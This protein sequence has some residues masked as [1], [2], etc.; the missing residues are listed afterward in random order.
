MTTVRAGDSI[1]TCC[2]VCGEQ[3]AILVDV[4]LA[5]NQSELSPYPFCEYC[6][7]MNAKEAKALTEEGLEGALIDPY[8][9][10]I[11][12]K[13]KKAAAKGDYSIYHPFHGMQNYP[14]LNI[15]EA[16]FNKLRKDGYKITSH[17]GDRPMDTPYDQISWE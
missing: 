5:G 16:V 4:D 8:L 7:P 9:N 3:M 6:T 13:I 15:R 1:D 10:F 11:Y 12:E 17:E 2:E 14:S